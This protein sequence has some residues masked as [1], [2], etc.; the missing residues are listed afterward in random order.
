MVFCWPGKTDVKLSCCYVSNDI[1]YVWC[2]SDST[3]TQW[4][5]SFVYGPPYQKCS[6]HFWSTLAQ[7][8]EDYDVRWLCIGD[9]N[10]ITA[11]SDKLGG[12][13]FNCSSNNAFNTFLNKFCMID[14][15]FSRNSCT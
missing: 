6:S 10:N 12:R 13:S 3:T 5:I 9:F 1:I 2:Y 7:F 8:G 14:L 15:G 4:M 11:Q